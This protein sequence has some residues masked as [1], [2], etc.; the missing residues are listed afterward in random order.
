MAALPA[1]APYDRVRARESH[2]RADA[3]RDHGDMQPTAVAGPDP[4]AVLDAFGIAGRPVEMVEVAGAWSNRV[5]R[6]TTDSSRFAVKE[7]LNPWGDAGWRDWLEVAW[8]YELQAYAAGIEMPEPIPNPVDGGCLAWIDGPDDG[9][10]IA[11][12]VHRW[13]SG[14]PHDAGPSSRPVAEWAGRVLAVLH[15]LDPRPVEVAGLPSRDRETVERW[16]ELVSLAQSARARWTGL[17]V[18]AEPVVRTIAALA[19]TAEEFDE[20]EVMSHGDIDQKNIVVSPAG[21]V[22]CDWDAAAPH[23]PRQELVD[24]AM[25]LA[26]WKRFHVARAVI[27]S[28][29]ASTGR[30]ITVRAA[31]LGPSMLS[32]LDWIRFNVERAL[33]MRSA[34][35]DERTNSD[36]LVAGLLQQLPH[37]A[38]VAQQ[39]PDLLLRS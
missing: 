26:G 6:L 30:Q 12:R 13:V 27:A 14:R 36:G 32:S 38:Y 21:P 15:G 39:A 23:A 20:P 5:Y 8:R 22:L 9:D 16:P 24:A 2:R 33:G 34:S 19:D 4:A 37:Q 31:D 10:L 7:M 25:S 18:Q 11:V 3:V 35:A 1:F 28:Y 29:E 17:L